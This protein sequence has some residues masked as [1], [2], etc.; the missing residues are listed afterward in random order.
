M[1]CL[2]VAVVAGLVLQHER[3]KWTVP[4]SHSPVEVSAEV[5]R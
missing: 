3:L 1:C 4:G 5:I 2:P